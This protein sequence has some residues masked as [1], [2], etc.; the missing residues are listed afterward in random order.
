[1]INY[2]FWKNIV[3]HYPYD[4]CVWAKTDAKLL[5]NER[6]KKDNDDIFSL[7]INSH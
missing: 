4:E 3:S 1:M 7:N 6:I 2:V 5:K